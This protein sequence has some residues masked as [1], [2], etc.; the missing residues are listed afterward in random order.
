[1]LNRLVLEPIEPVLN[2]SRNNTVAISQ[3]LY[4]I[5]LL[6]ANRRENTFS[7][8]PFV[9]LIREFVAFFERD[10]VEPTQYSLTVS[11]SKSLT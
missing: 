8:L 9:D 6:A 7:R 3:R 11:T 5:A 4:L 2:R 1:L 10:I